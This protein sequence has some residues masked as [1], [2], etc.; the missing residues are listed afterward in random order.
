M[1]YSWKEKDIKEFY[2]HNEEERKSTVVITQHNSRTY[3]VDELTFELTPKK[4]VFEW[5][6][7]QKQI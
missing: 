7:A 1:I 5:K 4:M 3:Q 2:Y 6:N